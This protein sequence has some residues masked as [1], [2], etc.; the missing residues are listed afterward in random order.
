MSIVLRGRRSVLLVVQEITLKWNVAHANLAHTTI[1]EE[2]C[3]V[4]HV[5]V[6][7][8]HPKWVPYL[9]LSVLKVLRVKKVHLAASNAHQGQV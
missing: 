6:D 5:R 7:T 9:A 4:G 8:M 2:G 3:N 1:L